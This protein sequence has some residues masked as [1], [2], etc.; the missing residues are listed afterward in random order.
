MTDYDVAVVGASIAGA[1]TATFLARQGASVAL[2]ESHSDPQQFKRMCTHFIQASASPTIDRLGLTEKIRAAGGRPSDPNIWTRYGWIS[3]SREEMHAPMRD[4]PAWNIR[5]EKLDPM[6]REMAASTDGVEPLLGHTVNALLHDG[7]RVSGVRVRGRDGDER[8]IRAKLV[9]AADGRDSELAKL[10][11]VKTKLKP[12]K[13]FGYFAYYRDTPLVTGDNAQLWMLDPDVVY[14]FPTDD[15]LTLLT[16]MPVR[17]KLAEF[18]PDPESAMA[19]VFETLPDG[20]R[21]DPEKR[22]SKVLGKL[23]IPNVVRTPTQPG[24]ALVGDAALAADPLWGVGC[25][26]AF[27]SSEWLSETVGPALSGD[28]QQIDAALLDYQRRHRKGLAAHEKFTSAYSTGRKFNA[29][30]KLSFRAA[31]RDQEVARRVATMGER[32]VRPQEV[33]NLPTLGRV[34]AV[35][36][37]PRSTPLGL[38]RTASSVAT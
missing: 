27:Q 3:I 21:V 23:E 20:P 18:K 34:L 2:I 10:A 25:G 32:W 31:A 37:R 29:M 17:D 11:G 14:A 4:W 15:N 28:A 6:L 1:S 22:V 26:W 13:R 30:E 16:V 12:H 36:L 9:V 5:R 35:N 24:L 33:L 38:R 19:R 7:G 8:E